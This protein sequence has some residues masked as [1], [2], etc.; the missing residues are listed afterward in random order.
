MKSLDNYLKTADTKQKILIVLSFFMAVGFVLN[1][2]LPSMLSQKEELLYSVEDLTTKLSKNRVKRLKQDLNKLKSEVLKKKEILN[3][4]QEDIDFVVS[5]VYKIR[6]AFF[7][8]LKWAKILDEMLAYSLKRDIKIVSLKNFDVQD[9]SK[10]IIKHKKTIHLTGIG[11]YKDIVLFMQ[12][13]E[14]FYALVSF[15]KIDMKLEDDKKVFFEFDLNV[16][17][18]GL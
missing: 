8:D 4:K 6:Y 5:N 3:K 17:G 14:N 1:L 13:I 9:G 15:N 2:I 12:Y 7:N 16:F 10:H 11:R 18:V